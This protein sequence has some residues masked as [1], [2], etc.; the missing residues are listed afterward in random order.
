MTGPMTHGREPAEADYG[1]L[2][3]DSGQPVVRFTRRLA[4]P[5][6]KV[7]RALTEP[8]HLAAWFPTTIDGELA[9]GAKLTF[10]FPRELAIPP[11]DGEMLTFDP[12]ELM[13]MLWGEETLRFELAAD[14]GGTLL[15]FTA[16]FGE[17]GKVSRDGAG[18]HSCLDVLACELDGQA[19]PWGESERWRLVHPVYVERFGP[20]ASRLGPPQ[21]W[22]DVHGPA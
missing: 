7:W 8:D 18:W 15:R 17:L 4:H 12:P 10:A 21:E 13:E 5:P 2:D 3:R 1:E 9:A 20:E 14:G 11:M 16:T 19:A 22:Q 6:E